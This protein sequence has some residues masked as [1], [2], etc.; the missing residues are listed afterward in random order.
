[1]IY[2]DY[3]YYTDEF[4]GDAI[5]E[6]S[7]V[8]CAARASDYI[9][10]ITMNRAKDYVALHPDK[11]GPVKKAC[12]ALAEQ[13]MQISEAK[14]RTMVEGGEVASES[15]G[16]HSISYRSSIDTAAALEADLRKIVIS[17]LGFTGLLYR[18][19]P[20]VHTTHRYIDSGE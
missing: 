5:P 6:E 2:A 13:Y 9:D 11:S 16:G 19:I 3:A 10:Q 7:F 12:C 20:N 17:Y 4:Y 15:V 1:M 14:A 8:R 18:G